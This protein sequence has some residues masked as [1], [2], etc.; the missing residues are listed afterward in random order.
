MPFAGINYWA[1]LIAAIVAYITSSVW[2]VVLAKPWSAAHGFAEDMMTR[3][4]KAHGGKPSP[5]P[6]IVAFVADVVM[7]WVLA[8]LLGHL[9]PG[10][11]TLVN[12]VISAAFVWLGFVITTLAVN[13]GFAMREPILI[14]LDGGNW[15]LVLLVMGAIIGAMGVG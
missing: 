1:I 3:M 14:A 6:F 10:Q 12:G 15:L 5:V 11:V 4:K 8:G 7:A 13:N 9:G 2:Y